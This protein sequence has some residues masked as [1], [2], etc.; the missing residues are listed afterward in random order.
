MVNLASFRSKSSSPCRISDAKSGSPIRKSI[1]FKKKLQLVDQF[2]KQPAPLVATISIDNNINY[3]VIY[4][5]VSKKSQIEYLPGNRFRAYG[6]GRKL[7]YPAICEFD[8]YQAVLSNNSK[9]LKVDYK[10]IRKEAIKSLDK[11]CKE[12]VL[13]ERPYHMFS[14]CWINDFMTR[15][16]RSVRQKTHMAQQ[17][18]TC[19]IQEFEITFEYLVRLNRQAKKVLFSKIRNMDETPIYVDSPDNRTICQVGQKTVT[20]ADSGHSKDR[21]T[22]CVDIGADGSMNKGLLLV[23]RKSIPSTWIIPVNLFV[24]ASDKATMSE[25]LMRRKII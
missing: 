1:N 25:Y 20:I 9:G 12:N 2:E 14:D 8:L 11:Y 24:Y 23:A 10:F 22:V 13:F 6:G 19:T 16:N 15:R 3:S 21:F 5:A 7:V 17:K 18:V 4:R